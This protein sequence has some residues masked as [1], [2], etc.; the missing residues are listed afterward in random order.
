M[1]LVAI[2]ST[3]LRK[4]R[5]KALR[6]ASAA[7]R[8]VGEPTEILQRKLGVHREQ[9]L[10]HTHDGIDCL[11]CT[12]SILELEERRGQRLAKDFC[13][14]R[15]AHDAA[16]LGHA[17]QPLDRRYRPSHFEHALGRLLEHSELAPDGRHALRR[18]LELLAHS[19]LGPFCQAGLMPE[20]LRKLGAQGFQFAV[21]GG[22]MASG[23][24]AGRARPSAR[25]RRTK[26]RR[27]ARKMTSASS[28]LRGWNLRGTL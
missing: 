27:S 5:A 4:S 18:L 3:C 25:A 1:Y 26:R 17:E 9:E 7:L 16:E 2:S 20:V 11:A 19:L 8:S 13:Q 24:A 14:H 15:F 21:R 22:L 6:R 23:V 12:E 10:S 28:R